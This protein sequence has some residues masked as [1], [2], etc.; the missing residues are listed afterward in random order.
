MESLIALSAEVVLRITGVKGGIVS[1]AACIN[2]SFL[3]LVS[4]IHIHWCDIVHWYYIVIDTSTIWSNKKVQQ[5]WV[6]SELNIEIRKFYL[7]QNESKK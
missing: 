5:I 1:L 7:Q 4:N 3:Y 6:T 2:P